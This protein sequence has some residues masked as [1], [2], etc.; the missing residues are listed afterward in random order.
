[1]HGHCQLFVLHGLDKSVHVISYRMSAWTA[2][3]MP[4]AHFSRSVVAVL[5]SPTVPEAASAK[6][7]NSR[8]VAGTAFILYGSTWL[9]LLSKVGVS[10][11]HFLFP[12]SRLLTRCY[13]P[14]TYNMGGSCSGD[15]KRS[16][17]P[18]SVLEP[19]KDHRDANHQGSSRLSSVENMSSGSSI[20]SRTTP[21]SGEEYLGSVMPFDEDDRH[22]T[23]AGLQVLDTVSPS[24]P[25]QQHRP[26]CQ[27]MTLIIHA[28][29][30]QRSA[31]TTSQ[32]C[33]P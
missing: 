14:A 31:L 17:A 15:A 16:N 29:R 33:A 20:L 5:A 6:S 24:Y 32:R 3:R 18:P 4:S 11:S 27:L 19:T 28:H 21:A 23:L 2:N 13:S 30:N 22:K 8:D 7:R 26:H 25:C 9:S 10:Y 12:F 1:M